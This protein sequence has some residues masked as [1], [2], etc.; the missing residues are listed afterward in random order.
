MKKI[1]K[2]IK[3]A[4]YNWLLPKEEHKLVVMRLVS[5]IKR[6]DL[7]GNEEVWEEYVRFLNENPKELAHYIMEK[8]ETAK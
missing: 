1:K 2:K 7:K 4:F 6:L 5:T 8:D 3:I